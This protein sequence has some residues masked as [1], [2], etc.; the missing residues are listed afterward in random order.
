[1]HPWGV[2]PPSKGADFPDV[3][4]FLRADQAEAAVLTEA[5]EKTVPEREQETRVGTP[6]QIA[7]GVHWLAVGKGLMRSNVYLVRAASSWALIDAGSRGCGASIQEAAAGLFGP[8]RSPASILLTHSHPD[9]AGSARELARLWSCPLYLHPDELPL[10]GGE[11]SVFRRY[12]NPL[13]RW[14]VLPLLRMLPKSR[15]EAIL[16]E[17]SLAGVALAFDPDGELPGL[18]GWRSIANPG[19]TPG[20]V[21]YFRASDRV[22][23]T[24]DAVVTV[25]LNSLSGLLFRKPRPSPPPRYV[26]WDWQQAKASVAALAGL[27]PRVLAG[28]HGKPLA[29]PSLAADLQMLAQRLS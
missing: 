3:D 5:A 2:L 23:L 28:G 21:S 24:G 17:S 16:A 19:H 11:I 15:R 26:T 6:V 22:L 25:D 8:D 9:H 7:P 20:H 1:V 12:P 14:L 18:P 13:D 4:R 27:E 10:A 29:G